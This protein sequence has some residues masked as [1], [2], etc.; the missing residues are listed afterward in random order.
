MEKKVSL[1]IAEGKIEEA[2]AALEQDIQRAPSE[3]KLLLLGEL[4]YNQGRSIDALNK[5]NAVLKLNS[6]NTKASAYVKMINDILNFYH[7]DLLNP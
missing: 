5:F 4:F 1:L 7:K 3:E 6:E 2:V